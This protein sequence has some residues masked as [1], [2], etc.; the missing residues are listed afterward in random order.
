MGISPLLI[1]GTAD[2]EVTGVDQGL[3]AYGQ[4]MKILCQFCGRIHELASWIWGLFSVPSAG[5]APTEQGLSLRFLNSPPSA[6]LQ[7]VEREIPST[8]TKVGLT[9][10]V[11]IRQMLFALFHPCIS[12][13]IILEM[14]FAGGQLCR[15]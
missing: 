13:S 4:S 11:T 6:G 15:A 12:S 1:P 2:R 7:P 8:L 9:I 3:S 5:P 10:P 14:C